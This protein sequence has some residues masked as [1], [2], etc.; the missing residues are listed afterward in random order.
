MVRSSARARFAVATFVA[1]ALAVWLVFGNRDAEGEAAVPTVD[2]WTPEGS[3]GTG[4]ARDEPSA[5]AG[6]RITADVA[7][8]PK[9]RGRLVYAS[10]GQGVPWCELE[11]RGAASSESVVTDSDGAWSARDEHAPPRSLVILDQWP[12]HGDEARRARTHALAEP[13]GTLVPETRVTWDATYVLDERPPSTDPA[14]ARFASGGDLPVS[15]LRAAPGG[16]RFW[17]ARGTNSPS[18]PMGHAGPPWTIVF[19]GH[20]WRMR[21][22]AQVDV[23]EGVVDVAVR[24]QA[25]GA[26]EG[27]VVTELDPPPGWSV[28]LV[29]EDRYGRWVTSA[30]LDLRS[31]DTSTWSL[32]GVPPGE[33]VARV[34]TPFCEVSEA[35]V[36]VVGGE[37]TRVRSLLSCPEPAG[38]I[39]VEIA[40]ESGAPVEELRVRCRPPREVELIPEHERGDAGA[41]FRFAE[42]P[43]GSYE[44]EVETDLPIRPAR[45][46]V[47]RPGDRPRFELLDLA[48]RV[49]IG[50]RALDAES[51]EPLDAFLAKLRG[52]P[53]PSFVHS[54]LSGEVVVRDVPLGGAFAWSLV[55]DGYRK[56]HGDLEGAPPP[57][58]DG[59]VW[60]P[61]ALRRGGS[62]RVAV[63]DARDRP[64]AGAQ[65][66]ADGAAAG[67]TGELGVCEVSLD[68]W[69]RT[70]EARYGA[71]LESLEVPERPSFETVV[72][73]VDGP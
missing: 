1:V 12:I 51:G 50:F 8:A 38:A 23:L 25:L 5:S 19:Q 14:R 36:L 28:E 57:D 64:V 11:I 72:F 53:A 43:Q 7:R 33:Y 34:V 46:L 40:R 3:S 59:V 44:I 58:E 13:D 30:T 21:A 17:R 37:T 67:E 49:A 55:R 68:A 62:L 29:L 70:L 63:R 20:S 47:A 16:R 9:L 66:S 35:A 73:R 48:P 31:P 69:P 42:L 41:V 45:R 65:L 22:E 71:W 54:A 61:A 18:R 26:I 32:I 24:W 27:T 39:E 4:S 15:P 6:R 2:A 52:V 10:T 56:A 60:I